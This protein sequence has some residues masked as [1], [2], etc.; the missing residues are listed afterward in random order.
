MTVDVDISI[1]REDLIA[2]LR[3]RLPEFKAYDAENLRQHRI[4][5]QEALKLFRGRC[6][7]ALKWDWAT[8]ARND[9]KTGLINGIYRNGRWQHSEIPSCPVR[10][11]DSLEEAIKALEL[12]VQKAYTLHKGG[13][14]GFLHSLLTRNLHLR[15]QDC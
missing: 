15:E 14:H 3:A 11:T 10:I 4:K 5:E 8:V 7:E 13:V 12:S 9:C 2:K 1:S 6:K